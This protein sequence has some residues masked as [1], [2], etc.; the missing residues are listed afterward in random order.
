MSLSSGCLR[1]GAL[2]RRR[3]SRADTGAAS[4]G[5]AFASSKLENEAPAMMPG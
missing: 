1:L 5:A 2:K 4:T 3:S